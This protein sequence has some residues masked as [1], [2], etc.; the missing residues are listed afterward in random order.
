MTHEH[1]PKS[2]YRSTR[3]AESVFLA[4][5]VAL[6]T[7]DSAWVLVGYT[8]LAFIVGASLYWIVMSL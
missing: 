3:S 7:R 4:R 5:T 1:D 6:H 2:T 8:A